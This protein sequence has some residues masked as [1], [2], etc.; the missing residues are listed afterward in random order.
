MIRLVAAIAL[1]VV[2]V[3]FVMANTHDVKLSFIFGSPVEVRLIFLLMSTF[4]LGA[5]ATGFFGM[6]SSLRLKRR[7]SRRRRG[8]KKDSANEPGDLVVE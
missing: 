4:L 6:I 7:L 8:S 1:T 2:A 3:V 5:V